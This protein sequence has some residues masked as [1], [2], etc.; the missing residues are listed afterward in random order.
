MSKPVLFEE[1]VREK[2]RRPRNPATERHARVLQILRFTPKF[3][4]FTPA[5]TP[6][7]PKDT[8]FR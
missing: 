3:R 8:C 5:G 2:R 6:N 1:F 7:K 4:F